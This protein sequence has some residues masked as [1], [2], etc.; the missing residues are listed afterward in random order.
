MHDDPVRHALRGSNMDDFYE[1]DE[2]V[3]EIVAAFDHGDRG[4][5]GRPGVFNI[6]ATGLHLRE[7]NTGVM[8]LSRTK[9]EASGPARPT[10]AV[11]TAMSGVYIPD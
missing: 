7:D 9:I 2:P 5:T 4:V 6:E 1:D 3:D 10:R 8:V 11:T